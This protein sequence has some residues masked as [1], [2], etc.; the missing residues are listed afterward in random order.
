MR[1]EFV[2]REIG[3]EFWS[4]PVTETENRLFP[5]WTKW[6]LSGTCALEFILRDILSTRPLKRAAVPSWCCS[7]MIEPFHRLG[8]EVCFYS[9]VADGRGL[10]C[11][12]SA[13]PPCD[14]TLVLSYFGY[15]A[16]RTIG[17]PSGLILRDLTHS[18][19]VSNPD[20]AA[21]CFGSLRKWAGFWTGGYAW[22]KGPWS[23][24][25]ALP[26]PD[27]GYLALRKSAMEDK[28]RYLRGETGEKSY[29]ALFEQGE[30]FLDCC[31]VMGGAKRDEELALRLD[32]DGLRRRR[33]ENA[34]VLL[35]ELGEHAL[36]PELEEED[37]PLFVPLLLET[38]VR[39]GLRRHLIQKEIYCPIHWEI[40]PLHRLTERERDIYERELSIVCDQRYDAEDMRRILAAIKE[41]FS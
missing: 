26:A 39:D 17:E 2:R 6:F 9:V 40:T 41:Y 21:Y 12:Y 32:V 18:L 38:P 35:S 25:T 37:C 15:T 19:F 33:R 30:D 11:D 1:E 10:I 27:E 5:A 31:P 36:F 3:S 34:A 28:L 8:V 16:Q 4:V 13:L 29:L 20:D 14:L 22:K 24:E 23:E 7:C